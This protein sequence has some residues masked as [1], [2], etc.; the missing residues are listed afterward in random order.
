YAQADIPEGAEVIVNKLGTAPCLVFRFPKTS[1]SHCPVLYSAPGVPFETLGLLPDIKEDICGH[2]KLDSIYHKTISTFGI[3]ESALAKQIEKWEESLPS[4]MHLAYLPNSITGVRLRLSIYGGEQSENSR[5]VDE[6]ISELRAILGD[7]IYGEGE[8]TLQGVIT[9]KLMEQHKTL[10]VAES[11]TG[12]RI[13]SLF[14]LIPGVSQCYKGSVTSYA[15]SIKTAVLGVSQEILDTK[16]AVSSECAEAM[17]K[18]VLNALDSDYAIATTG[19]AG[20][21]GGTP[22]K[23]VGTVWVGVAKKEDDGRLT[24]ISRMFRFSSNRSVNIDRFTSSAL[25]LL[26]LNL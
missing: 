21:D 14:T 7:A 16:G 12:G 15:N 8:D 4:D 20:P 17:A 3:P 24:V 2:F 13:S 10:A 18:G 9:S 23:P 22:E 1:Y 19:I 5:R 26:R 11:C 6:K 25:N